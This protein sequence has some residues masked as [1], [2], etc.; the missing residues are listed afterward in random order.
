M[1]RRLTTL[2]LALLLAL[3]VLA[4]TAAEPDPDAA[5][6]Q[7]VEAFARMARVARALGTRAARSSG[8]TRSAPSR[9]S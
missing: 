5:W 1:N 9:A 3:P 6:R 2:A 8:A 4:G 7:E